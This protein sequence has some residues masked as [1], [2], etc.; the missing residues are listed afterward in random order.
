MLP[1]QLLWINLVATVA[2][3]LPLA[4]EAKEPNVMRRS[5]RSP[6]EPVL[7]RFVV[8][9]TVVA[10]V[11]MAGGSIG[12]F[13]WEYRFELPRVGHE[14][15]LR[16]AQTMAVTTVILFQIFYMLMCRSLKG[17]IF[18]LGLFSNPT[19]FVGIGVLVLLQLGFIYL[20]LMQRVFSTAAL[21]WEALGLSALV[22]A[23]ILPVIGAEKAWLSR[24]ERTARKD[25]EPPRGARVG[26]QL[27]A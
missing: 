21:D 3:A 12:L 18:K 23:V 26:P 24:R 17:S 27:P 5:P 4:F 15:A 13:L 9:R 25:H 8:A 2:L 1:T 11:L 20:P 7:S 22:A 14:T 6:A 19:V 10:A 16:E